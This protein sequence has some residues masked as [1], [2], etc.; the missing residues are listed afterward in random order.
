MKYYKVI[1]H[2]ADI[3][4]KVEGDTLKNLFAASLEGMNEIINR[5]FCVTKIKYDLEKKISIT[6]SNVTLLLIDFLSK[7][8]TLTDI[9]NAIFCKIR[10]I[11]LKDSG[12]DAIIFG[13]KTDR[14]DQDIKAVTYH[15]AQIKKNKDGNYETIVVFDV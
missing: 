12:L 5:G 6:S 1:P 10:F 9:D 2:T 13:K 11:K 8:L 7:I 4:L 14:F 15:Q 3:R